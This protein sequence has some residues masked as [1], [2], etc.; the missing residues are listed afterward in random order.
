MVLTY[1]TSIEAPKSWHDLTTD[2]FKNKVGIPSTSSGQL[3]NL[4]E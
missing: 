1:N 2:A 4:L 3:F